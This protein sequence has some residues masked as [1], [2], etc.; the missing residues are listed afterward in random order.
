MTYRRPS[1]PATFRTDTLQAPLQAPV[2]DLLHLV[3]LP[4]FPCFVAFRGGG[5]NP[6]PFNDIPI[7]CLL[8]AP[9]LP[10][11]QPTQVFAK[12]EMHAR[13]TRFVK[14]KKKKKRRGTRFPSR[15][16]PPLPE[17]EKV[18]PSFIIDEEMGDGAS[19]P[20]LARSPP[21]PIPLEP[22]EMGRRRG[23]RGAG[24]TRRK[25]RTSHR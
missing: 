12:A 22:K 16:H 7:I 9:D 24:A 2:Q 5:F 20:H 19:V 18:F 8:P 14:K 1:P 13:N 11:S 23:V 17:G 15:Q 6:V 21:A 3:L 4:Q 10:L 25:G